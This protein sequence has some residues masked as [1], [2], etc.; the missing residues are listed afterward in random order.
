MTERKAHRGLGCGDTIVAVGGVRF[1]HDLFPVIAGP[2]L[3]ESEA[4]LMSSAEIVAERGASLLRGGTLRSQSS[5]YEFAGLGKTGLGLLERAGREVGLPTI[6]EVAEPRDVNTAAQHV[7]MIEVG[8]ANMQNFELLRMIGR[9]GRPVLLNRGPSATIDEWLWSAE[10]LL[11]EGNDQ[12]VMCERGI[13]TFERSTQ[14]TLDISAVPVVQERS[15]L[16]VIVD[17]SYAAGARNLVMP[18]ALAAQGV[19]ADGLA[20]EVHPSPNEARS[21]ALQQLDGEGFGELMDALGIGRMR[22]VVD[23]IDRD[24]VRLLAK[25]RDLSLAIGRIKAARGLPVQAPDREEELL[26][27]VREEALIQGLDP[28]YVEGLFLEILAD[29][30]AAQR[31]DRRVS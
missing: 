2:A 1:G 22:R 29:S 26:A 20:V 6:T 18:L 3:I 16:P 31:R 11:A 15:H 21:H 4:Q 7:D 5:P 8:A 17:P 9:S 13:R 30:R 19:G 24:L 12:V 23:A 28:S 10:Y 25:R 27:V 14:N